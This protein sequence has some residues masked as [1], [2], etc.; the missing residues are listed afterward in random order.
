MAR[1][2]RKIRWLNWKSVSALALVVV[3][4]IVWM[5]RGGLSPVSLERI[6][7]AE[8]LWRQA[9][10]RDYDMQVETAGAQQGLY[11][12]VVRDGAL[13]SIER[14]GIKAAPAD[15]AY[16]TVEGLFRTLRRELQMAEQ[17]MAKTI[18]LARFDRTRGYPVAFLRQVTGSTR[19][20]SVEVV[21]FRAR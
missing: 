18:I 11:A 13:R 17:S 2:L 9:A 20:V 6:D 8:A 12:L 10:I 21:L 14:D 1:T 4:G 16:W 15:G 19:S 5:L 3:V 7:A